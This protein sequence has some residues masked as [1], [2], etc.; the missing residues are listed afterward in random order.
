MSH[1]HMATLGGL[2][3]EAR[4]LPEMSRVSGRT[5]V[6]TT[7]LNMFSPSRFKL[8]LLVCSMNDALSCIIIMC[9]ET[10]W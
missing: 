5:K 4:T 2:R 1:E 9:L 7:E 10:V 6:S 8:A 3:R